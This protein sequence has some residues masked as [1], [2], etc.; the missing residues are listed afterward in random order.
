MKNRFLCPS[1]TSAAIQP[2]SCY[3]RYHRFF[4]LVSGA[5]KHCCWR[6]QNFPD[7]FVGRYSDRTYINPHRLQ[8][9]ETILKV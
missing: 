7:S 3:I 5:V 2:S 6:Y 8:T 1:D 9:G 4:C